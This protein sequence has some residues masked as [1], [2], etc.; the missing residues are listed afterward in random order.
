M[1]H[2]KGSMSRLWNW[3]KEQVVQEVPEDIA[4]CE[5]ECSCVSVCRK[6]QCTPGEWETREK[7]PDGVVHWIGSTISAPE[8][9][10]PNRRLDT[11]GVHGV[12]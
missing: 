1:P 5:F 3:I 4:A 10:G 8:A 9:G 6:N 11:E 7:R 2:S 12:S